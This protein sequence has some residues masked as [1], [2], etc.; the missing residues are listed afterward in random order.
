MQ[1][2]F[3]ALIIVVIGVCLILIMS[4]AFYHV[5]I[6]ARAFSEQQTEIPYTPKWWLIYTLLAFIIA[7]S[8]IIVVNF[9]LFSSLFHATP[10]PSKFK[11]ALYITG[12][13]VVFD[14]IMI[15]LIIALGFMKVE[16]SSLMKTDLL[17][18]TIGFLAS[19]T[20]AHSMQTYQYINDVKPTTDAID[21]I[22]EQLEL[23]V[24]KKCKK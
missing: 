3:N 10:D 22:E 13:P 8:S 23:L 4:Y 17:Q 5:I 20:W 1:K 21:H 9:A 19:I 6:S 2:Q 18:L 12:Q 14:V 7:L 15:L 16:L 11:R 24:S